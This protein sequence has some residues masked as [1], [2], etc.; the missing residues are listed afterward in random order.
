MNFIWT[1][2][3]ITNLIHQFTNCQKDNYPETLLMKQIDSYSKPLSP[4][5][6]PLKINEINTNGT[7]LLIH[8]SQQGYLEAVTL[9]LSIRN[10]LNTAFL[11][12][13]DIQDKISGCT[14]L[15]SSIK[16]S[17]IDISL[18]LIIAGANLNIHDYNGGNAL[19]YASKKGLLSIVN[20][21]LRRKVL[22]TGR[23][24]EVTLVIIPQ[25]HMP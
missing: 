24:D 11:V 13:K 3:L 9:L 2:F 4:L 7:T 8:S 12:D 18:L 15:I 22:L 14:A 17:Y 19:I 1:Y 21:M 5:F 10:K 25:R 20:E 16:G 23:D 6:S